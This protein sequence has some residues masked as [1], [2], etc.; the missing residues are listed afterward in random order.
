M[1]PLPR[2]LAAAALALAAPV[3]LGG[4][5]PRIADSNAV[6]PP[7]ADSVATSP[8]VPAGAVLFTVVVGP[9]FKGEQLDLRVDGQRFYRA[10]ITTPAGKT[11]TTR[12]RF[13]A[14]PGLR[15][16]FVRVGTIDY[17]VTA[18]MPI[19]VG[20]QTC[21]AVTFLRNEAVP[22]QSRILIDTPCP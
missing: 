18:E 21:A 15:K 14:T 8:T 12:T 6:R 11:E 20:E 7:G 4:C 2:R 13:A 16:F 22:S 5:W 17:N 9:A 19:R 1:L 3:A 10:F